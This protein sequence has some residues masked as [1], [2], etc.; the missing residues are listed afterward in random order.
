MPLARNIWHLDV[1][2]LHEVLDYD[3]ETG[4]LTW[5]V[6]TGPN[7][8]LGQRAGDIKADGYRRIGIDGRRYMASHLAWLHFYGVEPDEGKVVD[9]KNR[10]RDDTRIKNL[11]LATPS[12]DARNRKRSALN[13]TGFKGAGKFYNPTNTARYRAS[14]RVD[15][16]R[17]FI[18]LFHT[19]EEAYEAYCA[20]AKELHGEFARLR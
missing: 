7:C 10:D 15:G 5:R 16:K 20:K 13:S 3:P 2:R 11:R 1:D 6:R 19:P 4:K 14:I 12:E 17:I 8:K 18:G 9:F